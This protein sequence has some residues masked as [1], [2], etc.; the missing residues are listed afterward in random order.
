MFAYISMVGS[1]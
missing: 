1:G